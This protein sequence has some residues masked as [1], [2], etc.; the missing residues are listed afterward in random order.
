MRFECLEQ[1]SS[2]SIFRVFPM[3][4]NP[5]HLSVDRVFVPA[6]QLLKM[7][8]IHLVQDTYLLRPR[9]RLTMSIPSCLVGAKDHVW[10]GT[11]RL[12]LSWLPEDQQIQSSPSSLTIS[13]LEDEGTL[14]INYTWEHEDAPQK[15]DMVIT[16][17]ADEQ[18]VLMTWHDTWHQSDGRMQ[19]VGVFD[20]DEVSCLGSYGE[21]GGEKWGW[22]IQMHMEEDNVFSMKMINVDPQGEEDWAVHALYTKV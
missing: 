5:N 6:N 1:G 3:I 18:S 21:D 4:A 13:Y 12:H 10:T 20:E 15:G 16:G 11:S 9:Y 17:N 22:K 2:Q 7:A 8:G 14:N 19:L